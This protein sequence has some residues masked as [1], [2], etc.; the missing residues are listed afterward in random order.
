MAK[1]AKKMTKNKNIK[2]CTATPSCRESDG[3]LATSPVLMRDPPHSRPDASGN[4]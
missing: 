2:L 3:K 4:A 1:S